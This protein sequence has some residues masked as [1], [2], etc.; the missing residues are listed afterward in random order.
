MPKTAWRDEMVIDAYDLARSGMS[1]TKIAKTLGVSR[2]IFNKWKDRRPLLAH[3]I[4]K[5][6]RRF[7]RQD[8]LTFRDYVYKRLSPKNQ[9]LWDRINE[10]EKFDNGML[11]VQALLESTGKR[12]RQHLFLYALVDANFNAS[13][14]CRKLCIPK[15]T[16]EMWMHTDP[17]FAELVDE[18]HWHKKNFFEAALVSKVGDGDTSAILFANRTFN[19]DR[20]YNDKIDVDVSGTVQHN[21]DHNVTVSIADLDLPLEV[22]LELRDALRRHRESENAIPVESRALLPQEA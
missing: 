22:R 21:H 15:N 19:K 1:D 13:E 4:N 5:G 10:C 8:A 9:E 11:R 12:T 6:R 2:Q 20:G 14:A 17:D 3:A 16:Y 7:G 18:I